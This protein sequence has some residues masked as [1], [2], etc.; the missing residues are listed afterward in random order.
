MYTHHAFTTCSHMP[1]LRRE[2]MCIDHVI[3]QGAEHFQFGTM[4]ASESMSSIPMH[5]E[6]FTAGPQFPVPCDFMQ[7]TLLI[8]PPHTPHSMVHP[9]HAMCD[10]GDGLL[11]KGDGL[12]GSRR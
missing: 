2:Q 1:R 10:A 5:I 6:F 3:K 9:S 4:L 8:G 12:I 7:S 11:G